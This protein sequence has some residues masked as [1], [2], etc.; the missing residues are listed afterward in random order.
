M[1]NALID[2]GI[3]GVFLI[4]MIWSKAKDQTRADAIQARYEE[5]IDTMR[6]SNSDEQEKIRDRY[7]HVVEKYD[8]QIKNF[9]DERQKQIAVYADERAETR[10]Q[11]QE[12][13]NILKEIKANVSQNGTSIVRLQTQM[14]S[15][16]GRLQAS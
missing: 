5:R 9:A 1:I 15:L 7:R 11:R 4:Y 3:A 10:T 8:N 6:V 16:S 2:Y 14:N 13:E 12:V